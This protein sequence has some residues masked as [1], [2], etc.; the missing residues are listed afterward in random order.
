MYVR[1]KPTLR[2]RIPSFTLRY[3]LLSAYLLLP[4]FSCLPPPAYFLLSTFSCLPAPAYFLKSLTHTILYYLVLSRTFS[5]TLSDIHE[6]IPD[7]HEGIH[8]D[9]VLDYKMKLFPEGESV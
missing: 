3:F 6:G 2:L 5:V 1:K 4:T 7:I 8:C 9:L